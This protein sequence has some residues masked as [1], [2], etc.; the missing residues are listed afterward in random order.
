MKPSYNLSTTL[1]FLQKIQKNNNREWF[2]E[3]KKQYEAAFEEM[4]VFADAVLL[5][6]NKKDHIETPTGKKSLYRIYN[7]VRFSKNK[8]P[9][10]NNLGG[11]LKRATKLLRGGYYYHIE[12]G[13][14]FAAG[15][16]WGPNPEDL[17]QIRQ[18]LSADPTPLKAILKQAEFKKTFGILQG[19]QVKTAPRGF[20]IDDPGIE[21]IRHKQ[22]Y[23]RHDFTNEEVKA[24][25]F[26]LN[27][28]KTFTKMRP[29]LD[30][31]SEILT[32]DLNGLPLLP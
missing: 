12:P 23:I 13:H 4:I 7:D 5:E 8:S 24:P 26:H 28:V 19:D 9:Y 21:F 6:M 18:Q 1:S 22:Y 3:N 30:Y 16:F 10:K 17:L 25:D 29:F 15:G 31:M 2:T 20:T 11:G 14:S 32:T 27:V